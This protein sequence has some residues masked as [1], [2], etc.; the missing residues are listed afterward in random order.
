MK[1]ET[2]TWEGIDLHEIAKLTYN[3]RQAHVQDGGL[4]VGRIEERFRNFL[5]EH[6]AKVISAY[7]GSDLTG[8][9]ILHIKNPT[10]LEMNPGQLLGG[11]PVV[12]PGQDNDELASTL[13]D[14]AIALAEKEGFTKIEAAVPM[15][16]EE[17]AYQPL[18]EAHGFHIHIHYVEMIYQLAELG[19]KEISLPEGFVPEQL[20]LSSADDVYRCYYNA[21][22]TGDAQFFSDQEEQERRVYFNSLGYE[23]AI[24]EPA[25]VALMKDQQLI[26]FCFV[27]PY[28]KANCHISCMCIDS[29]Y[30]RRGLGESLLHIAMSQACQQGYRTITLGTDTR[31]AAYK[32]YR[33]NGFVFTG[34]SVL[35]VW[36]AY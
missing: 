7:Q 14:G 34:G 2:S 12:T 35:W 8:L 21:F 22:S 27:L 31:M 30:R 1:L 9:L 24:N 3:A 32:L 33:K 6:P 4:T 17:N 10:V 5:S 36:E 15:E 25:S 11:Y 23:N 19:E 16:V 18:Y 28:G 20:K 29:E 26:G 13:I